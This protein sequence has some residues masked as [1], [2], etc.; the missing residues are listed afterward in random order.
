M[1]T[2]K[3]TL[4]KLLYEHNIEANALLRAKYRD[5]ETAITKYLN[6]IESTPVIQ[7]FLEEALD[8]HIPENF[9]VSEEIKEVGTGNATFGPFPP[10]YKGE[11]AVA[12]SILKTMVNEHA[13]YSGCMLYA[14][15]GGSKKLND[16]VEAFLEDVAGRLISGINRTLTLEGIEMGLDSNASQF[17]YFGNQGGA[18]A[19]M[20]TDNASITATQTN[21]KMTEELNMILKNLKESAGDLETDK[22]QAAL[23]AVNAISDALTETKPKSSIVKIIMNSLKSFNDCASFAA[24]VTA[25]TTFVLTY[26]PGLL[27]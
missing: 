17:N 24:N 4:K 16:K 19:S 18:I 20:A 6:F 22:Q 8:E 3:T 9:N 2:R 10:D 27:N 25:L 11:S 21:C 26:F 5:L 12:Y 7:S 23:E 14:Y 15:A 13:C 1:N